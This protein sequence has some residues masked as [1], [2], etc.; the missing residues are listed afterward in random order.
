MVS[1]RATSGSMS[2][3]FCPWLLEQRA[4]GRIVVGV[5]DPHLH[6]LLSVEDVARR[7][8]V[9]QVVHLATGRRDLVPSLPVL[10]EHDQLAARRVVRRELGGGRPG[11][12][13]RMRGELVQDLAQV[14]AG[15]ERSRDVQQ[16]LQALGLGHR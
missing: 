3:D 4:L 1:P 16:R 9:G 6:G 12:L 8:I 15:G 13:S 11:Q 7:R 2:S 14:E 5:V 10:D